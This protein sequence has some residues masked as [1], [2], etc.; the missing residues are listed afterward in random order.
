MNIRKVHSYLMDHGIKPSPQRVAI[1]KY[2]MENN[3][4]P[5][6]ELIYSDLVPDMPTLSKTT[7]YNTLKLFCDKKAAVALFIDDKN[8]RY[9]GV[10]TTHAHFK[11]KKCDTIYDVSLEEA[12][13]PTCRSSSEFQLDETQVYFLGTCQKCM[14]NCN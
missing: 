12:D 10:M 11:C 8:V 13:V 7:V 4:H 3:V 14:Q 6:V 9:D 5:D 2:L 1:M